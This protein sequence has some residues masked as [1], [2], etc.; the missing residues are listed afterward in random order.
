MSTPPSRWLL[1]LGDAHIA[2][3]RTTAFAFPWTHGELVDSPL[4]DRFRVYFSDDA[5]WPETP[6]FDALLAEIQHSGRFALT[7]AGSGQ[8]F[9]NVTLWHDGDAVWFRCS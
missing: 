5:Q 4:F 7:D 6:E 1:S 8:R 9:S 2:T 3:I